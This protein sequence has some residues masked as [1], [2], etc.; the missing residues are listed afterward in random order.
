MIVLMYVFFSFLL[1]RFGGGWVGQRKSEH[2]SD[3]ENTYT[4]MDRPLAISPV[5]KEYPISSLRDSSALLENFN[6]LKTGVSLHV[7]KISNEQ[8]ATVE[9]VYINIKNHLH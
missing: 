7:K 2:C 9:L 5:F 8:H 6:L 4:K 1:F 3:F